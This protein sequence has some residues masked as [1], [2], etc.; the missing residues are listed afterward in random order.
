MRQMWWKNTAGRQHRQR[1]GHADVSQVPVCWSLHLNG[2]FLHSWPHVRRILRNVTKSESVCT[3][4]YW[5]A[6]SDATR[7]LSLYR[8][9]E[10]RRL[11]LA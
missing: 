11:Q 3:R 7:I 5:D 9:L 2:C 10:N 4:T 8:C 1:D 6:S